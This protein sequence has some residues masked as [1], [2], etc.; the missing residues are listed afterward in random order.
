VGMPSPDEYR[1]AV[2]NP[3]FCFKDPELQGGAAL[4]D[5]LGLPRAFSGQFAVVFRLDCGGRSYAVRCFTTHH[6][7]QEER[8]AAIDAYLRQHQLP[9]MVQ[10]EYQ[11][12]GIRLRGQWYPILKMEWVEG[13][14]LDQFVFANLHNPQALRQLAENFWSIL[15]F[16]EQHDIAH[17]DLQHGNI[18]VSNGHVRLVDYDG[19]YV[20]ALQGRG[21]HEVG[22]RNY[23]HPARC[24]ADFGPH[25]D[26][27]SALV[28][29][30]SL[31]ALSVEPRLWQELQGGDDCLLLRRDDFLSPQSSRGLARLSAIDELGVSYYAC[32]IMEAL[33]CN[34]LSAIPPLRDLVF[35]SQALTFFTV[36]PRLER[37]L[38]SALVLLCAA[39][40]GVALDSGQL[41][42]VLGAAFATSATWQA[43]IA[44]LYARYRFLPQTREKRALTASAREIAKERDTLWRRLRKQQDKLRSLE[45]REQAEQ[46]PYQAKLDELRLRFNEEASQLQAEL[47]RK[48]AAVD[49]KLKELVQLEAEEK[50]RALE[51]LRAESIRTYLRLQLIANAPLRGIGPENKN[52]LLKA[53]LKSAAD[54]VGVHIQQRSF[55]LKLS[56]VAYFELPNGRLLRVR[57][58]G[59]V[60]AQ[61]VDKWRQEMTAMAQAFVPQALPPQQEWLISQ[62]YQQQRDE[63]LDERGKLS[64]TA[65]EKLRHH[66]DRMV[67][68]ESRYLQA[69]Q[70]VC[71]R[72]QARRKQ[73]SEEITQ[74]EGQMRA[75]SAKLATLKAQLESYK[76]ITFAQYLWIVVNPKEPRDRETQAQQAPAPTAPPSAGSPWWKQNSI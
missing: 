63:L 50:R 70:A 45:A 27:F 13:Q 29:Y 43:F 6:P 57:G 28:I 12:Q 24:E 64:A 67:G 68:E 65:E 14:T 18:L 54:F 21:S 56:T 38:A 66:W 48:L 23:Q 69:I 15:A 11:P 35:P 41:E 47:A 58:I 52:A 30:T 61:E 4:T 5:K 1:E 22:Q 60:K 62:K 9:C 25:I 19:M 34:D 32:K 8:Y 71:N 51:K 2:Q 16:L 73:L 75:L 20:P 49:Q 39:A 31:L 3:R 53:G 55:G 10:F 72:Y 36:R 44:A 33:A 7:D 46:R 37:A 76:G 59:P 42:A 26:R 17:G 74:L 40:I